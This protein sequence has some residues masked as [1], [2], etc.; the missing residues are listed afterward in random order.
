MKKFSK[1]PL[2]MT[3]GMIIS[4]GVVNAVQADTNPFKL[5]ELSQSTMQLAAVVPADQPSTTKPSGA[6]AEMKCG[7]MMKDKSS[8][9]M[10]DMKGSGEMACG[11]MMK[12]MPDGMASDEKKAKCM[13]MMKE[14][15]PSHK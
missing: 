3:V 1:A 13:K 9:Q 12:N 10:G 11:A 4:A 7:A 6:T 8:G 2:T 5:V 14:D 15:M